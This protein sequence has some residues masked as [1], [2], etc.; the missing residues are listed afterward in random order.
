MNSLLY[1]T[2][3]LE[4][5]HTESSNMDSKTQ[6]T[7]GTWKVGSF[8]GRR[9]QIWSG[10]PDTNGIHVA[11]ATDHSGLHG[12][13]NAAFIVRACNAHDELVAALR[14]AVAVW[15]KVGYPVSVAKE[16]DSVRATLSKVQS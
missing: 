8:K 11:E 4:T 14:S 12:E 7:A 10:N 5:R 3:R 1:S 9:T 6:R 2:R 16:V 15:D 13:R